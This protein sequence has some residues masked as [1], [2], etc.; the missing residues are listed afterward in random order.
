MT[1][2]LELENLITRKLRA[3]SLTRVAG[4]LAFSHRGQ[5]VTLDIDQSIYRGYFITVLDGARK[6]REFR[7][8]QGDF[9]WD[10]MARSIINV[11][12]ARLEP[13]QAGAAALAA[14]A[15]DRQLAIDLR[16]M[17]A[18]GATS[19][20]SIEP[21]PASPGRLRVRL[22]E[23]DLDPASV[24]QLCATLSR[25]LAPKKDTGSMTTQFA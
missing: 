1:T 16:A 23:L 12:D 22:Q 20:L 5:A 8:V 14:A 24:L 3:H 10:T 7:A 11:A 19:H 4:E 9:D 13:E 15:S 2:Q 18:S 6:V 17:V 25:A 21:S